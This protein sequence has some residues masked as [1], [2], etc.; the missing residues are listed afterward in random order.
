MTTTLLLS[1]PL[2]TNS[3]NKLKVNKILI[4]RWMCV[5]RKKNSEKTLMLCPFLTETKA[6]LSLAPSEFDA[7]NLSHNN[8]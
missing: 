6:K 5:F 1:I 3:P 2:E 8:K 7:F 4:S